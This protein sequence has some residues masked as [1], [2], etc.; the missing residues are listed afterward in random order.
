MQFQIECNGSLNQETCLL[1]QEQFQ[2]RKARVIVCNDRGD[3]Y[4][5]LCPKCVAKGYNLLG[6][7]LQQLTHLLSH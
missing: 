4:G 1:C 6:T 5:E 2:M 3:S 7:K